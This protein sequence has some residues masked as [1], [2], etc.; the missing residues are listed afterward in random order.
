MGSSGISLARA[1]GTASLLI[2]VV[3][4][5]AVPHRPTVSDEVGTRPLAAMSTMVAD[6][7]TS[8][9]EDLTISATSD[10]PDLL[11]YAAL[12]N[13][14][15]EAA[16][17]RWKA[18]LER[19][20][21]VRALPDPRFTYRYFIREVETRVGPQQQA[22]GASQ[23]FPWLGKLP[24]RG[25][26]AVEAA[27]AARQDYEA[28]KRG[29]FYAVKNAYYEYYYLARAIAVVQENRDLVGYLE[30]VA[31]SKYKTATASQAEVIRAQ[32]E[33]GKLED[34]WQSLSDLRKPVAARLN[35]ALNRAPDAELPEPTVIVEESIAATDE[36]LR[37]WLLDHSPALAALT[38]E[39]AGR[40]YGVALAKRD[41]LPDI[42]VG[43]DYTAV[44]SPARSAAPGFSNPAALRSAS[45]L[46]G[47]MGDA[48]D[49]YAIGKSFTQGTRPDDAGK[50]IWMVSLSMNLPIGREK[51][52]AVER[53]AAAR[54]QAAIHTRAQRANELGADLQR[55]LYEFRD[56]KRKIDL[57]RDTLVPKARQNVSAADTAYRTGAAT[58][59]DLV[60]AERALLE[61][62]LAYEKALA[63]HAQRLAEL[64]M[65]VGRN[66][67]THQ[68]NESPD[69]VTP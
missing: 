33:L 35:A 64:E 58:F 34:R 13:P 59:L 48:I 23:V 40:K 6:E 20:P 22:L 11:A 4:C 18:A 30:G 42:T 21:Q 3:G 69:E 26:I 8:Q 38:H 7:G 25:D 61:F 5:A 41:A 49:W 65:L 19:V 63:T 55:V 28:E 9:G 56:A 45:R 44:G 62:G 54:Y 43:L 46:A 29:L 36:Q 14:G 1:G 50:D 32:V 12:H 39:I 47:G 52:A 27:Q 68:T 37:A 57:Y 53:E 15:L 10:L 66:I 24:L 2:V 16:F 51:Y 67:P 17:N 60:D 31:R